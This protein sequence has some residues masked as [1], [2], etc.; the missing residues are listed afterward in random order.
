MS[1]LARTVNPMIRLVSWNLNKLA[2]WDELQATGADVGLLQEVPQPAGEW[3]TK[4]LP[5][6]SDTWLTGGWEKRPWRTAIVPLSERITL[7]PIISGEIHGQDPTAMPISRSG[8]ITA[9]K[10]LVDGTPRFTAVSVYAPWERYFGK[11]S[12]VWADGSA[13]RILSD[14]SPLLWNQRREPVIV[15]GDWNVLY[16]YGEKGAAYNKARYDTVFARAE[17]LELTFV[18]PQHPNGRL[19]EPRPAELPADSKC[20]PT[21]F[22]SRQNPETAT[23]QLDFV[24]ASKFIADGV[25][26]TA[27]NEPDDWGPSDHCRVII[28][29]DL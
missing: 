1:R 13:H 10:V 5:G 12:P 14:L 8:T 4:V 27:L 17:A 16:G 15:S 3:A 22:H 19:A 28:D 2:L 20:V 9:A 26:A 21:Y 25:T 11:D 18:G 23:R 6:G 29:V 24:F 7:E